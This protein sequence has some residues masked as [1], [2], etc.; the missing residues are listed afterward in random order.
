MCRSHRRCTGIYASAAAAAP[1]ALLVAAGI[2]SRRARGIAVTAALPTLITWSIEMA[3]LA[4][5]SN[6]VRAL[7]A[8]P[9]GFVAAWLVISAAASRNSADRE[10]PE[11]RRPL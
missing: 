5:P 2:S 1:L 10:G 8:V 11:I 3:G 4:H 9:L 6:T 7:A